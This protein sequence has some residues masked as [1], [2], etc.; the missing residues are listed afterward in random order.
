M[1][2]RVHVVGKPLWGAVRR[3]EGPGQPAL[4]HEP[5]RGGHDGEAGVYELRC[6]QAGLGFARPVAE[7]QPEVRAA[8]SSKI[9]SNRIELKEGGAL[10]LD[11]E[12]INVIYFLRRFV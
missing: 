2:E 9:K 7:R 11:A 10:L 1:G 8:R 4:V 12:V 6:E 3:G 5:P